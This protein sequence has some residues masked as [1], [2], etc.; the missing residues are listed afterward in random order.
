MVLPIQLFVPFRT[1]MEINFDLLV[2]LCMLNVNKGS[3]DLGPIKK[4]L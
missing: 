1:L 4:Y 3:N 2:K